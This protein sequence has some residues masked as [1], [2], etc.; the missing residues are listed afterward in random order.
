[1]RGEAT[2]S[3]V[4]DSIKIKIQNLPTEE[5]ST[6]CK[7][8][9]KISESNLCLIDEIHQINQNMDQPLPRLPAQIFMAGSIHAVSEIS[10]VLNEIDTI[11]SKLSYPMESKKDR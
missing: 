9:T 4:C 6:W 5:Q 3:S 1:M 7:I 10:K 11:V 8:K 2:D